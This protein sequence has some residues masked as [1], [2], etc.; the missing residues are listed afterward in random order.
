[1]GKS[2][3]VTKRD[4]TKAY[5]FVALD[6]FAP[7]HHVELYVGHEKTPVRSDYVFL[8]EPDAQQLRY[9]HVPGRDDA[10]YAVLPSGKWQCLDQHGLVKDRSV[11]YIPNYV[12]VS[13]CEGFVY[14]VQSGSG[15]PIKI[16]WS[17][18][19]DRRMAELQVGNAHRLIFLG[20]IAGRME[21][22][23]ATHAKFAH[24]RMEG[25]WFRDAP[26]VHDYVRE[27]VDFLSSSA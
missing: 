23:S 22:E 8:K 2:F 25:E 1:M 5:P 10:V 3:V 6:E 17:Q 15:G 19:V 4:L 12:P 14:F 11:R 9:G 13:S 20:K 24:L 27:A 26:E 16:G 21:D 7:T 18:D